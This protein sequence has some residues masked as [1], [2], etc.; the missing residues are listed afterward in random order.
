MKTKAF[1]SDNIFNLAREIDVF[2]ARNKVN[3]VVSLTMSTSDK[4][5]AINHYAILIYT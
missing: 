4:G 5:T 2:M 3:T 1:S